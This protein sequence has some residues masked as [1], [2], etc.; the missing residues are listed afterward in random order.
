MTDRAPE[1]VAARKV[2]LDVLEALGSQRE[3]V[4]VVGAQAIYMRSGDGDIT[5][6]A[7]Y[8]TDA[9]LALA[10][11]RIAEG[12]LDRIADK[13]AADVHRLMLATP[14]REFLRRLRPVVDDETASPVCQEAIESMLQ[15]FG[16]PAARGVRMACDA[17][18]VAVPPEQVI[19][20]C[21]GFARQLHEALPDV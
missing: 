21:T 3:A 14:L 12:T 20:V 4:I 19:D 5:G 7:P 8:T 16:T 1:Y 2:L 17:L 11:S 6:Y 18:R 9:D 13:D 15:L 10:P